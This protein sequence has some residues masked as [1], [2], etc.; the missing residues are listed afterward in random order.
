MLRVLPWP[1]DHNIFCSTISKNGFKEITTSV[2]LICN[3]SENKDICKSINFFLLYRVKTK[4]NQYVVD[5][6]NSN[7]TI[8]E[9]K[10]VIWSVTKI[11]PDQYRVFIGFPPEELFLVDDDQPIGEI[12]KNSR[13]SLELRE[14]STTGN[15]CLIKNVETLLILSISQTIK[16]I[17]HQEKLPRWLLQN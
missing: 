4:D 7:D 8:G 5:T 11:H 3:L 14:N 9:L 1:T 2:W 16:D 6:L 12:I 10:A 13:E 17:P 15:F